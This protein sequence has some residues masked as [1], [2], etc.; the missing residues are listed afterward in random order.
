L[1]PTRKRGLSYSIE[2]DR[3]F[4]QTI[5]RLTGD[6]AEVVTS[7]NEGKGGKKKSFGAA[8]QPF[9]GKE[10]NQGVCWKKK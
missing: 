6:H 5:A 7:S 2:L 3:A 10:R 8:G 1:G 9:G 4:V